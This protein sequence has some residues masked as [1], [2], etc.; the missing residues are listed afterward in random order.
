VFYGGSALR[1]LYGLDRFSE[2]LDFSLLKPDPDFNLA[3]Y[4]QAI[5]KKLEAFGFHG[6]CQHSCRLK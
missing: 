2:D 6:V 4:N 3:P 5:V 1:V